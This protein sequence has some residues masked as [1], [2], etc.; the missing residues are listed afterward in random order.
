MTPPRIFGTAATLLALLL[1]PSLFSAQGTNVPKPVFDPVTYGAKGDGITYDTDAIQKAIDACA[2]T[3]GSVVLKSG[4]YLSAELT[5]RGGMTLHL[6]KGAVL[7]GGTNAVDYPVLMPADTPAKSN[8]RSLLYACNADNLVIEGPGEI[9]GRCKLVQMSGREKDRPSLIR[10]FQSTNVT[11]RDITLRNPRMWT[12][13][14]SECTNLLIERVTVD[15]PPDCYNLDG[16]DVCDSRDVIVRNCLVMSEDDGI[17][18]KSH[19]RRGLE[20][21]VVENNRITSF[22]ANAIKLGTATVGP[23]T[24]LAFR[25]NVIDFVKLGGICIESVD[26]ANVSDVSV[27]GLEMH[28]L[29]SHSSSASPSA[30]ETSTPRIWSR[31]I[32]LWVPSRSLDR[33][34]ARHERT[35]DHAAL[36]L[37]HRNPGGEVRNVTLRDCSF[38][39]PGGMT[40]VP[41]LPPEREKDYPESTIVGNPPAYGVFIRHASGITLE[42]VSFG[43]LN[44]DVR[45]WIVTSEASVSTNRCKDLGLLSGGGNGGK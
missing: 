10:I 24:H 38:E 20:N 9:D 33:G 18:L 35:P 43:F 3:G 26:G 15:A 29:A 28:G 39:M 34:I 31:P 27:K 41:D 12:Q 32:A 40:N 22:K 11:V 1:P 14:Y 16:I 5:L 37:D 30:E 25:N 21:I 8:T 4:H 23:V 6:G 42:N 17:C 7:L 13:V 45:P 2:G 19:G 44:P 36:L